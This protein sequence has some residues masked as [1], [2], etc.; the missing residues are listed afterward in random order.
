MCVSYVQ[1]VGLRR[2]HGMESVDNVHQEQAALLIVAPANSSG[3][4]G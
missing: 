3:Y 4:K 2:L 1:M